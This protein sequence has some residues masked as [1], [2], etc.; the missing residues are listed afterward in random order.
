MGLMVIRE[1]KDLL[2]RQGQTVFKDPKVP[3]VNLEPKD[4]K[5]V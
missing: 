3:Q 4:V 1:R 2:D 5:V